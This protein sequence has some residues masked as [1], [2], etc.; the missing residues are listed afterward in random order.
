MLL[1]I[2][3]PLLFL[4]IINFIFKKTIFV[5]NC[6]HERL[7]VYW[8]LQE[9]LDLSTMSHLVVEVKG[10]NRIGQLP[11]VHLQQGGHGVDVLVQ[12]I[13]LCQLYG[14]GLNQFFCKYRVD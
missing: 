6:G 2:F 14:T 1:Q 5:K 10:A 8:R 7:R 11:E 12:N 4:V 13:N 9:K 3:A